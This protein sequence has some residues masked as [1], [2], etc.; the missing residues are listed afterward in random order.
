MS[1]R[2]PFPTDLSALLFPL[3]LVLVAMLSSSAVFSIRSWFRHPDPA[4]WLL[5]FYVATA[6][7][8]AGAA[9]L[10]F[11]KLPQYRERAFLRIGWRHLPRRHQRLY[12]IAFVLLVPSLAVLATLLRAAARIP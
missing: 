11:A 2:R 4:E 1:E 10:F 6:V 9:V 8:F 3:P 12:G 5:V 7:A